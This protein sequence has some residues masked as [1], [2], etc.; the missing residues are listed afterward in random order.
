MEFTHSLNP[1]EAEK[2]GEQ[3]WTDALKKHT[4]VR[5]DPSISACGNKGLLVVSL[6]FFLPFSL[7]CALSPCIP[8]SLALCP[9]RQRSVMCEGIDLPAF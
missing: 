8:A 4:L 6:L 3:S 7:T 1:K 2:E 9:V 5:S